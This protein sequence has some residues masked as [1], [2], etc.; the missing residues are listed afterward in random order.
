VTNPKVANYPA[1]SKAQ[2]Y[3]ER[4]NGIYTNLL[5]GLHLTFNGKPKHL[6]QTIGGMY[7]LRLAADA[8]IEIPG[9]S[10]GQQ[11]APTFEYALVDA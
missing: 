1:G 3:A 10:T 5:N 4:F 6:A 7:E 8:L 11:A 2:V 9:G